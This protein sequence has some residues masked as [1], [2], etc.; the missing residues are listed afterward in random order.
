M[1][2]LLRNKHRRFA[3]VAAAMAAATPLVA[4]PPAHA[5]FGVG[6]IVFDPGNF[7]Q[8]L[9]ILQKHAEELL[10]LQQQVAVMETM[11]QNWNFTRIEE[12]L[13]QMRRIHRTLDAMSGS[14]GGLA[15]RFPDDWNDRD[16]DRSINPKERQWRID[17]RTRG[18]QIVQLHQQVSESM[19]STR[20]RVGQYV[21]KSNEAPGQLAAQQATNELLAVQVQ[22][23]QELQALE[24]AAVRQDMELLAGETSEAEWSAKLREAMHQS[25]LRSIQKLRDE[26]H[27]PAGG[28]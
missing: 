9:L 17:R 16:P 2:H 19:A 27:G 22:Q 3:V 5:L 18:E 1:I 6:D 13:G 25:H 23:L 7:A 14:L 12:T 4:T 26:D 20:E 28:R 8:H 10:R 15:G 21:A 11:L 24:I